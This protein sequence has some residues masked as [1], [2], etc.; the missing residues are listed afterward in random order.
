LINDQTNEKQMERRNQKTQRTAIERNTPGESNDLGT[1]RVSAVK[2][3]R[4]IDT[5]EHSLEDIKKWITGGKGKFARTIEQIRSIQDKD[6]Q[7]ELKLLL[8]AVMFSGTFRKRSSKDLIEHSGLI[9]MDFDKI[10]APQDCVDKLRFDP[11]VALAFI[12]PRGNGVKAIFSINQ[13]AD[14]GEAFEVV[15]DYCQAIYEIEADE[16]GK[17]VSRLCFLSVDARA[18]YA[19]DAVPLEVAP[20]IKVEAPR[21]NP[22]TTDRVGD[23]YQQS[24]DIWNR[25]ADL[26]RAAGW[27]T[28]RTVGDR[29]F[30]TRPGKKGGVSGTLWNDG[31]FYCFTDQAAPLDPSQG[32]S[33]FALFATLIH[34]GNYKEAAKDLAAE[35]PSNEPGISGRDFYG[36][37]DPFQGEGI[38]PDA[39][40]DTRKKQVI[41]G[42]PPMTVVSDMPV[43]LSKRIMMRYPVLIDGLL[44]RGTKMIL[45]G[46]SKSYK[47]WTLLNLAISVATGSK[48]FG[49]QCEQSGRDVI[50][51]NFEVPHEFFLSRVKA[52]CDAMHVEYPSNMRVW[53]LRG[54]CNDLRVI[55]AALEDQIADDSLALICIDPI[56]KALGD[57]DENSAGDMGM[58]MN[59]VEA[60]VERT[61]AA[62]AFGAHYSKGNQAEKDPLD[63]VSG[64]GV[65]A[66]DPDTIMGLTAHEEDDCFT[67]HTALR[68][69]PGLSPFVVKWDFPLFTIEEGLN[70]NNLRRSNQKIS[71]GTIIKLLEREP[72]GM[73]SQAIVEA[74]MAEDCDASEKTIR[75]KLSILKRSGRI[76]A[77]AMG[78]YFAK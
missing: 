48:W 28:G 19:P 57:R 78:H 26:L 76:T 25:S 63:R 5:T 31:G 43:D 50:F 10:A 51:L 73:K 11:H 69:F 8:P 37:D 20:R 16:S 17:D 6:K 60:L 36:K 34:A 75:N 39:P 55:L 23:K 2:S 29:T 21:S 1:R 52:V 27:T 22:T 18:H 56:Y 59:E 13:K 49:Q 12:S 71:G 32:Y 68:N 70:P 40:I 61:G 9:C 38:E 44:H 46:G 66:R 14:H 47:T 67:V 30:C 3:A 4:Q 72:A 45:G 41:D 33:A 53:S 7:S 24:P 74:L 42:L 58:L 54:K 64:S 35:F 65:F 15:K 77:G 62:A